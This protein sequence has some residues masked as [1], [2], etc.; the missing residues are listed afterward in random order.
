MLELLARDVISKGRSLGGGLLLQDALLSF[1]FF[2]CCDVLDC[3]DTDAAVLVVGLSLVGAASLGVLV[4]A[5]HCLLGAARPNALVASCRREASISDRPL[6]LAL[7]L[8]ASMC[9]QMLK[10]KLTG[11]CRTHDVRLKL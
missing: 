3:A 10:C 7:S 8:S 9:F 11:S 5:D 2:L 1:F 4:V 6:I